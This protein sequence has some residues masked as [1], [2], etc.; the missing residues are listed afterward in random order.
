MGRPKVNRKRLDLKIPSIL[1]V[2][3]L[4][5]ARFAMAFNRSA[6]SVPLKA[7]AFDA[8]GEF[9]HAGED[10]QSAQMVLFSFDIEV[11][12]L[13]RKSLRVQLIRPQDNFFVR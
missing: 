4:G 7:R 9:A 3:A 12:F 11:A 1:S 6:Q 2:L 8:G 13:I 10:F 5:G